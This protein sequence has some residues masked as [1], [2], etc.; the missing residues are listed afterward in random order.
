LKEKTQ[1]Q[2]DLCGIC[3]LLCG[4]VVKVPRKSLKPLAMGGGLKVEE[5][6]YSKG[7][8]SQ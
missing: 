6:L 7:T 8:V 2:H 3:A 1:I 4:F 5:S